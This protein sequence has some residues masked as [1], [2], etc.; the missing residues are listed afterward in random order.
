MVAIPLTLVLEPEALC[1][2]RVLNIGAI[3]DQGLEADHPFAEIALCI[4]SAYP[5]QYKVASGIIYM[6]VEL[7][8]KETFSA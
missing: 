8:V 4:L 1:T 6:V 3:S 5:Y 7:V 2:S